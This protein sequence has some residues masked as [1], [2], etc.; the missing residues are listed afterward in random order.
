MRF[1]SRK[2]IVVSLE[3]EDLDA[4]PDDGL[5][6]TK[7][8]EVVNAMNN[9]E[10]P[11][12][13]KTA[14]DGIEHQEE[15][16]K[17]NKEE[18]E[19]G[20]DD[21]TGS[22]FGNPDDA[23]GSPFE[24]EGDGE[25]GTAAEQTPGLPPE[26]GEDKNS[27]EGIDPDELEDAANDARSLEA[28]I[29]TFEKSGT[30]PNKKYHLKSVDITLESANGFMDSAKAALKAVWDK[31]VDFAVRIVDFVTALIEIQQSKLK[32]AK[33]EITNVEEMVDR[34]TRSEPLTPTFK[35]RVMAGLLTTNMDSTGPLDAS[36]MFTSMKLVSDVTMSYFD[37]VKQ[38][39]LPFANSI[40]QAF[41]RSVDN[42]DTSQV[43][44][45]KLMIGKMTLPSILKRTN[46][47][48]GKRKLDPS[49]ES[50]I[51]PV[52]PRGVR[53]GA[54]VSPDNTINGDTTSPDSVVHSKIFLFTYEHSPEVEELR[55]MSPPQLKQYLS[56]LDNLRAKASQ[57]ELHLMSYRRGVDNLKKIILKQ[58]KQTD[59][60]ERSS[61]ENE[62]KSVIRTR[63]MVGNMINYS[64]IV[65]E[66]FYGKPNR[67]MM[68][69]IN[70]VLSAGIAYCNK[71]VTAYMQKTN[72]KDKPKS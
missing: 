18:E 29:D 41:N 72:P 15:E 43:L 10:N 14:M 24:T 27:D 49:L 39:Y 35:N 66:H 2:R 12:N 36:E 64:L 67:E 58:K 59:I 69:F 60:L 28:L 26:S 71:S 50:Y 53:M 23:D 37:H 11:E 16:D 8:I 6:V 48:P 62:L 20:G 47:I 22:E 44:S 9:L 1:G 5:E 19:L 33:E 13:V 30:L 63:R 52:M 3:E 54:F 61:N 65:S 17:K 31:L 57:G 70:A 45:L 55:V 46:D 56:L 40:E 4:L 32:V 51:G 42:M 34:L 21:T 25:S 7:A 68:D 38:H